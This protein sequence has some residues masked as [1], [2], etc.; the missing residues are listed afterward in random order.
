MSNFYFCKIAVTQ[1]ILFPI[2]DIAVFP[3]ISKHLLRK[4]DK[5]SSHFNEKMMA[6]NCAPSLFA[7]SLPGIWHG[8]FATLR[9]TKKKQFTNRKD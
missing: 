6:L 4:N 1:T 5:K 9:N 2:F 8:L 3:N 7:L